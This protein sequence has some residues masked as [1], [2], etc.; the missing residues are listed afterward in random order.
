MVPVPVLKCPASVHAGA[1]ILPA[2]REACGG[3]GQFE[4]VAQGQHVGYRQEGARSILVL[5]EDG[6]A[7]AAK[8]LDALYWER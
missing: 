4:L 6:D 7:R 3:D 5:N 1:L 2:E 8:E